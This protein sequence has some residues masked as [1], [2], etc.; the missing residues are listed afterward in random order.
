MALKHR[1][2]TV[3]L[4]QPQ[5]PAPG[6]LDHARCLEHHLLHYR[7]NATALGAVAHGRVA[8]VE[9]VLANQTQQVHGH[10]G[11]LAYQVVG[12]KLARGQALQ[13]HVGLEL[14]MELLM[15]GVIAVQGDDVAGS[16]LLGQRRCPALDLIIGQQ[17]HYAT[18]VDG[19]LGQAKDAPHRVGGT[20][21]TGQIQTLLPDALALALSQHAP[22]GAGISRL[23]AGNGLHWGLA[24]V[25]LDD[26]C[27]LALQGAG[28][29]RD[30]LHQ[31]Q[32]AK[33]RICPHQQRRSHQ[34]CR[35][36]QSALKVVLTLSGRM[37]HAG[38]QGQL[39]AITQTAQIHRKRA[40]AINTGISASDQFFLGE[41][42]VHGKGVQINR[43][44]ATAEGTEINGLAIDAAGQQALVHLR[45]QVEPGSRMG[46]QTLTQG[47]AR[48]NI[49]QTQGAFE[50]SVIAKILDGI[51]VVLAQTQQAQ[52]GLEDVA[53]GHTRANWVSR[54]DQGIDLD[55]LEILADKG[56]TGVRAEVVGQF[57]DNEVGHGTSHLSGERHFNIK[58]LIYNDNPDFLTTKSRIQDIVDKAVR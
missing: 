57:L 23:L 40:I 8:L 1:K 37:L 21:Y 22:L 20:A 12:V 52:V 29:G 6:M 51:E 45:H 44:V 17:Q 13:I 47:G 34:G 19:A 36:R 28:L 54:I 30:F 7:L 26:E 33:A 16:E 27:H 11:E 35:H 18:L 55:R 4:T 43:G 49:L 25:P 5:E 53:I 2:A 24:R 31:L 48:R 56:Q 42:V 50:E 10:G 38:A 46:I 39:Q 15:G 58:P 32:R 3:T 9:G 41:T 14:G